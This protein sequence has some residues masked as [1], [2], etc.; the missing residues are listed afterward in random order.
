MV[1]LKQT[2]IHIIKANQAESGAYVASP[3]F[4]Q[5]GYSWYRDGM[6][7]AHSMDY[8]GEHASAEAFHRWASRTLLKHQD[9]V[10]ALL[11][12]I[13]HNQPLAE[14]DYLPTRFTVDGELGTDE[15]TDF[16]LDGYGAWLWGLVQHCKTHTPTLWDD[17]R[18]TVEMLVRYLEALWQQP[19]YDC[20]EEFR[21]EIHLSTLGALYG[22]IC[23]VQSYDTSLV[24]SEFPERIR[25]F[26][27]EKGVCKAGHFM[28]FFGN[29]AVD[30]S[31]LWMAVPFGLVSV[32]DSRFQKTLQQI[33]Q[34]IVRSSGGVYRYQS[35]TYYGGGEWLLL[36]CWLAWVYLQLN[37]IDEAQALIEWTE[38][39]ASSSGEMPEQVS[40]YLLGDSYYQ[41]W[42]EKWGT[43]ANPL[44]WS[45]A[46]YLIVWS[47]L[48]ARIE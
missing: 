3:T 1:D 39:Q 33:E 40:E 37:R 2:S 28:K 47:E 36:T 23:A 26:A 14:T 20:W 35:D 44:L 8:V 34:D 7:I 11:Y 31:L 16:Q 12:K 30:A 19:N 46:M 38:A 41:P 25:T 48:E 21:D 27:L 15:W 29:Q 24:S 10:E 45:H 32:D 43:P 4:S 22:G 17:V 9:Q 6:W 18:P 42:V 5:Y 13:K